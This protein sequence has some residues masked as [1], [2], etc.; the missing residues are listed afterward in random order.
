[1]SIMAATIDRPTYL[2]EL[3]RWRDRD[4][5]KVV[6]GVRRC[7]KS[8]LLAMFQAELIAQGVPPGQII[9]VDLKDL[10][11]A[12]QVPDFEKLHAYIAARLPAEARTYVFIDEV[13]M[14]EGF[15]RAVDSLH[16]RA[17]VDLYL[18]GSNA[19]TLS[20]DLAT[21]LAGRYVEI[22]VLPLSFT[23]FVRARVVP[24]GAA[25]VPGMLN[26]DRSALWAD[27]LRFGGFPLVQELLPDARAVDDYL[28]GLLST[29]VL[30]DVAVRQK[31]ASIAKLNDVVRFFLDNVGNQTSLRRVSG[32]LVSRGRKTSPNTV[33]SYVTG[34]VDAFVLYPA[35]RWDVQGLRYLTGPDK[36]YVVDPGL[37]YATV[38]YRGGD[39]GHLL[40]NTVFFELVR[41]HVK[42]R[43]GVSAGGEIDF[44]VGDATSTAYYQ[45]AETVRDPAT[46]DRELRSL[47][48]V[49]DHHPKFLLTLDQQPPTS[50]QGIVQLSAL[51]WLLGFV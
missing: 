20:G 23:E 4:V 31:V 11:T 41:R 16:L 29:V 26:A 40:E 32:T 17:D 18:T 39:T 24:P 44:V 43:T 25:D 45:V 30:K 15:E 10:E 42:V 50:H 28:D 3:R 1:M 47:L 13:Q 36:Y 22:P 27:Y 12:A 6:T 9:H 35:S 34:L 48:A 49:K 51:D 33:E 19:V 21:R 2:T 14:V 46:L 8:T 37:R 5:I 7:G 38:G